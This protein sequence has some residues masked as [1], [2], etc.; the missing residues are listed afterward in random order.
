MQ[1]GLCT[2]LLKLLGIGLFKVCNTKQKVIIDNHV[3]LHALILVLTVR[4]LFIIGALI[5]NRFL[6]HEVIL[7]QKVDKLWFLHLYVVFAF[8]F[9]GKV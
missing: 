4:L 8:G 3:Q 2:H 7:G 9:L 6:P 1:L 5:V